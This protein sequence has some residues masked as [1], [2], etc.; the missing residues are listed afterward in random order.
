MKKGISRARQSTSEIDRLY[1]SMRHMSN[2]ETYRPGGRTGQTI[3]ELLLKL[4]PEIYGSIA[5]PEKVELEGLF[6]VLDRLPKGITETPF[7]HFTSNEGVNFSKFEPII[8]EKRRRICYRVDDDQMNIE[9]TRGRSEI[10]DMLTHLTFLYNEGDKIRIKAYSKQNFS[11]FRNWKNIEEIAL[12]EIE[13][14]DKIR[15]VGMVAL[16]A[17]LGRTF[18]ETEEAHQYFTTESDP[19]RFFRI[20]YWMGR[21]AYEDTKSVKKREISFSPIL[22]ERIGHHIIGEKWANK[23]KM[24]LKKHG[25]LE[26]PLHIISSNMHSV[27]NM[28]YAFDALGE[29]FNSKK[30]FETYELLSSGESKELRDK[31]AIYAKKK[32]EIFIPDTS[33]TNMDVQIMDLKEAKLDNTA[34]SDLAA[35]REDVVIV[36]DYA[37][38]EQ[39]FEV[40]DELLKPYEVSGKSTK[41]NVKS[42]S[43]MGKAGILVGGKGDI[44]IP[45][46]HII[47]GPTDNYI[48]E[49]ELKI[50]DFEN[51]DVNVFEGPMITV[52]GTSLQNKDLLEYFRDSTWKAIGLE[53]EG[54]HYQKAIQIASQIRQYIPKDVKVSYAY[55]ASDNPLESG[56]TLASGG[57]GLTGVKPTYLITKMIL[58]K[59]LRAEDE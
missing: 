33:G 17:I 48:F 18:R 44:M 49:N 3:R 25:L 4:N 58:K 52:L 24:T 51:K 16:S 35:D 11:L 54:G 38:G 6:Y 2:R 8:P 40:M 39:A 31:V 59:I 29:K 43:I 21:T 41:M 56:S 12:G 7:I 53:M 50:S 5:D 9:V 57:L 45:N 27:M 23:I 32:G 15:N 14:N 10:Y 28:F 1:I 46:A 36:M 30:E 37:F 20:I 26:R 55:Y 22:R 42:I 34:F 19:D 13:V 47:E